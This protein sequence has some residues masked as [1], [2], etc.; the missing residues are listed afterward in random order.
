MTMY[1]SNGKMTK[2]R[3]TSAPDNLFTRG[4]E[5]GFVVYGPDVG[6]IVKI[7]VEV[8]QYSHKKFKILS[9]CH[10]GAFKQPKFD[11]LIR[12]LGLSNKIQWICI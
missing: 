1:G 6:D 7:D 3:L 5:N 11:T 9:I 12:N 2:R 4:S 10:L 8:R